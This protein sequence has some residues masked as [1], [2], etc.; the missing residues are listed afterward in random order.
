MNSTP[1]KHALPP[2]F[3]ATGL[4][5]ERLVELFVDLV[6]KQRIAAGQRPAERPVF[7]KLHGAAHGRLEVRPDLPADRRVGVFAHP[8]LQ[9]W[10]RFSSDTSPT[11]PDLATTLGIG[12]KLFGVPNPKLLGTGDTADFILQNY[13]V[14]FVDNAAEMCEFTYAGVVLKDYPGYLAKHP[15]T[16]EI[17]NRMAKVEGS[18]LTTTYWSVVPFAFGPGRY[19][20]YRLE[21]EA[22]PENVACDGTNYLA[23]DLA[24]RLRRAEA[25]FKFMVQFQTDPAKMP[26]DRATVE[27]HSPFEH[28]ATL[29]L[30]IQ[31]TEARGQADYGQNLSFNI[32]RVPPEQEPQGSIAAVR[33]AVYATSADVRRSANGDSLQEP[34]H[35]RPATTPPAPPDTCIVGAVIHPSIG[36]A[37]VG[38]SREEYFIGPEVPE[39]PAEAHG[40]YR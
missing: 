30:P 16:N 8:V 7:R 4:S 3:D 15:K 29:I 17:L 11:T 12:I 23:V 21:P 28:I 32:W 39:P 38:T 34:A 40:F 10:V 20:K 5:T 35:P 22:R 26:L 6:Q 33:K 27:W 36:I 18:V 25:R 1:D 2:C 14:F 19:V 37:R 24:N 13:P 9:A 31:D